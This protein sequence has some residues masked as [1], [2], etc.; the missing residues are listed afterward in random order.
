MVDA[1]LFE[2]VKEPWRIRDGEVIQENARNKQTGHGDIIQVEGKEH[3][4]PN[5]TS[6]LARLLS[7]VV[8]YAQIYQKVIHCNF[9]EIV[10]SSYYAALSYPG[11]NA[12]VETVDYSL[13]NIRLKR[14][15][16][17]L[18]QLCNI[19][20]RVESDVKET[21]YDAFCSSTTH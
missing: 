17:P 5:S 3:L 1:Q 9:S 7:Q 14:V 2:V 16:Q 8:L 21:E 11:K 4:L 10:L 6:R 19:D 20:L 15:W 13:N 12:T 18:G